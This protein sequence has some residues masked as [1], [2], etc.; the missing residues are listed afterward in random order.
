MSATSPASPACGWRAEATV[1]LALTKLDEAGLLAV[2]LLVDLRMSR[3]NRRTFLQ[4]SAIAGAV[5]VPAIVSTTAPAAAQSPEGSCEQPC[6]VEAERVRLEEERIAAE[7]AEAQRL[8]DERIA[9]EAA[10]AE[11]ERQ[12][13][14]AER[15]AAEQQAEAERKAAEE[16]E[17]QRQQQVQPTAEPQE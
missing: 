13:L 1:R 17:R 15:I 2:P 7:L 16:A 5:A 14:E 10:A 12:R 8:E 11:A 6:T 4:R 3:M 9:A